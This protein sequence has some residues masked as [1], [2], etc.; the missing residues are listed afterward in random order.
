MPVLGKL[1]C[2]AGT[3]HGS[4][5]GQNGFSLSLRGYDPL[6]D[7]QALTDDLAGRRVNLADPESSLMLLK[8]TGYVPHGGHAVTEPGD[9]R[10]DIIRRWIAE[11]A[12]YNADAPRVVSIALSPENP[13]VDAAGQTVAMKVIARYSDGSERDVSQD[14]FIESGD[15]EVATADAAGTITAVR[16]GE[17]AM[18]ARYEGAYAAT[19]LTVMGDRG[20]F[21]F[22]PQPVY[23]HIDELVDVKLERMKIVPSGL[24]S[25]EEFLRRVYLDLTGLPPTADQVRAFLADDRESRAKR[26]AMIDQ[27][28]GSEDFV[29]HW[30]NRWADLLMVNGRFLGAEG[31]AAYRG[32]IRKAIAENWPYD[33]FVREIFTATGSNREHPAGSYFKVLRSPD[34]IAETSTQV[35]LGV[36]F[37]CNKC[38]DHPFERWTQDNYYGWAA[39]FAD[40]RLEKDPE[41]GDRTIAGSAVEQARP[42]FEIVADGADGE[43]IHLRTGKAAAPKFPYKAGESAAAGGG[44]QQRTLRQQAAEWIT[45]QENP[46]FASSYV[47]RVWA[48]LMGVGL[49]EPIDDIRAG[50]PPTNPELLARLTD[51]FIAGGFD[52]RELMRTICNSRTYQLSH[53]TNRWNEDDRRNYSHALPRRLPAEALYDA[54]HRVVGSVSKLPG[55]PPGTRAAALPDSMIELESGLLSKL[56]RPARESGCECERTSELQLGPVMALL[57]GPTFAEAIDDPESELAK[58]EAATADDGL[59]V[60]EVFLR[61]LNRAPSAEERTAGIEMLNT[62]NEAKATIA[63]ALGQRRATLEAGFDAWRKANRPVDWRTLLPLEAAADMGAELTIE[64]DGSIFSTGKSGKGVYTIRAEAPTEPIAGLR[65]EAL[66]DDRLPAKGPGRAPNG[67]FVLS[68]LRVFAAPADKP[69]ER[70]KLKLSEAQAD[71]N[72]GG[73]D[74]TGAIDAK[75]ETGWAIGGGVGQSHVAVFRL[76]RPLA[77]EEGTRLIV[78]L[79]HQFADG[80]HLLGRFRLAVTHEE[81]PLMRANQPPQWRALLAARKLSEAERERL[82]GYYLSQDGE[83]REL[84]HAE[85]L[86]ANPRLMAVQ[87]LAWALINSPAFL[88]NH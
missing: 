31:A 83:Y 29:E 43:M 59:L 57:N 34:L 30:T 7:H 66:A 56:G 60:D 68:H 20:G 19:T 3:C 46:Y 69:D 71:I 41:S 36:R 16:R 9:R 44:E 27:L 67:N 48:H 50:N 54:V 65:V 23:N 47:N 72:Q 53:Q 62:P 10:Y 80:E 39:F 40:V 1:G 77:P 63:A 74:V 70:R 78:E 11:G 21:E 85:R 28:I 14:A 22:T 13:V 6:T 76:S 32:W 42:L 18:L 38:H 81:P 4:R 79:D 15:A 24:C 86:V 25:D 88:F 73:Y 82:L 55:V 52:V 35:F 84:Q 5:T 37:N 58:L 26:S 87:D 45:S 64:E 33:K 75:P 2:N 12:K 51:D 8:A 17:A 49:I 61:V